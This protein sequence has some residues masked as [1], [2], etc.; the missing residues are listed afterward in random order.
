F[1]PSPCSLF[2]RG[3]EATSATVGEQRRLDCASLQRAVPG[4]IGGARTGLFAGRRFAH[5]VTAHRF[6]AC[7]AY[8]EVRPAVARTRGRVLRW[9]TE[10]VAADRRSAPPRAP[11]RRGRA[12]RHGGDAPGAARRNDRNEAGRNRSAEAAVLGARDHVLELFADAV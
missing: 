11:P 9:L 4:A 12:R 7:R 8:G 1:L 2:R 6:A 3:A 5:A 10:H